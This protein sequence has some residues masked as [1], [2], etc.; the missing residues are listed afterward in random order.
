MAEGSPFWQNES[1]VLI[2]LEQRA[3]IRASRILYE[4]LIVKIRF[5]HFLLLV[6]LFTNEDRGID[7][8]NLHDVAKT[9]AT[10]L[11][12]AAALGLTMMQSCASSASSVMVAP[13]FS[14]ALKPWCYNGQPSPRIGNGRAAE[15][16]FQIFCFAL[17][18]S[19]LA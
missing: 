8:G 11:Y 14:A 18:L 16:S 10:A 6:G 5:T 2:E 19:Y 4:A 13:I 1:D 12:T 17:L 7:R 15:T 3:L 9:S